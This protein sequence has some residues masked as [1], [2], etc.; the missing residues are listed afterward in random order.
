MV[1]IERNDNGRIIVGVTV[2]L[3]ATDNALN[4]LS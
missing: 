1:P 3:D 4:P 2:S